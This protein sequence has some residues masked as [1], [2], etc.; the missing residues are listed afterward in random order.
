MKRKDEYVPKRRNKFIAVE[1]ATGRKALTGGICTC[2]NWKKAKTG[3]C[4]F[5]EAVDWNNQERFFHGSKWRFLRR[6]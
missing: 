4:E 6:K 3:R 1:R 2:L 5:V